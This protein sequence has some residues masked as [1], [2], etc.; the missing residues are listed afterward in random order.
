MAKVS[1]GGNTFTLDEGS[2][3]V[4]GVAT[5]L[6]AMLSAALTSGSLEADNNPTVNPTSGSGMAVI[7]VATVFL[8]P[9]VV[10][11]LVNK[12]SG[13]V[14]V[15]GG[16]GVGQAY[17]ASTTTALVLQTGG[18]TG[19]VVTGDTA[20]LIAT[21]TSGGG[22][23]S[24]STG[25]G[26]DI[27]L[28]LTGTNTVAAGLGANTVFTGNA[29]DLILSTGNDVVSGLGGS[30][31]LTD[32][33][34]GGAGNDFIGEGAK[35]LVFMGGTGSST[36]LF[37]TGSDT[38][39]AGSGGGIFGGGSAGNNVMTTGMTGASTIF[40]GGN[41]DVITARG[42]SS[43]LLIAGAGNETLTGAGSTG[44]NVFFTTS[45]SA[46]ITEGS[47]ADT[48]FIYG[49]GSTTINGGAGSDLI[50]ITAGPADRSVLINNFT[51]ADR[52]SLQGYG[53]GEVARALA[54]ASTV[55]VGGVASIQ[56]TLS[57][58]AILIF[59]GLTSLS[60]NNNFI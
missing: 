22:A 33:V 43:N 7:S 6:A 17:L 8:A 13:A 58:R 45:G 40:G 39:T 38:I 23:F 28:G 5:N 14:T 51:P 12:P 44:N 34:M 27:I 32:T 41:G 46:V 31:G 21:P 53:T 24:F 4:N 19:T 30:Q 54:A 11:A 25:N 9:K 18:G 55:S 50:A 15:V 20:A 3:D 48:A 56:I 36:V 10:A 16:G 60:Q 1:G 37:S 47:G 57:D 26:D 52:V 2:N 29:T 35:N 42:A 49:T 59:T